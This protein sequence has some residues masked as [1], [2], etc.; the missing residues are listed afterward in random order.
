MSALVHHSSVHVKSR[1]FKGQDVPQDVPGQYEMGPPFVPLS[2]GNPVRDVP[3][4]LCPGTKIFIW[5]SEEL[6]SLYPKKLHWPVP[7]ETLVQTCIISTL[8]RIYYILLGY[9]C[10]WHKNKHNIYKILG[11]WHS[12]GNTVGVLQSSKLKLISN[13]FIISFQADCWQ[14]SSIQCMYLSLAKQP[15]N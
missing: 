5:A 8:C 14:K 11:D 12:F 2:Q 9:T 1:L 3:L 7:L 10:M 13:I 6:L 4:S 15:I